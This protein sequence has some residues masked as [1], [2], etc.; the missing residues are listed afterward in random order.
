M[1]H[2]SATDL[3]GLHFAQNVAILFSESS[4][5]D[6]VRQAEESN[7]L[8]AFEDAWEHTKHWLKG[9]Y[10]YLAVNAASALLHRY[11][12]KHDIL[13]EGEGLGHGS[14]LPYQTILIP[15]AEHLLPATIEALEWWLQAPN[16][17][18][19]VT[20]KTNIPPA[21]LGIAC[22]TP[23]R[24]AGYTGWRWTPASPFSDLEMWEPFYITSYADYTAHKVQAAPGSSVLAELYEFTGDLHDGMTASKALLG[25]GIVWSGN[26]L[27]IAN[28]FLEF[29]GSVLQGHVNFEEIRNWHHPT[30][31]GDTLAYFVERILKR[32]VQPGLWQTRLR[33]FGSYE[34]V[35]SLRHDTDASDDLTMLKAEVEYLV[36]ATYNVLDHVIS[37]ESTSKEQADTWV[38]E[39]SRYDFLE[40]SLH[41]HCI[42]YEW[43]AGK[44]LMEHVVESEKRLGVTLYTLG[45]HS[46]YH[47]HPETL[48]AMDYLFETKPAMLGLCTFAYYNM[49]QYGVAIPELSKTEQTT[50]RSDGSITIAGHGF[51][52]PYHAVVTSV[53][54]HK[55]LRG[56]DLTHEYDCRYDLTEILYQGHH[57]KAP[58]RP[59]EA[60]PAPPPWESSAS[61]A[62]IPVW[63]LGDN[64]DRL[65]NGVYTIQYHPIFTKDP[66]LNN[67]RGTLP[68]LLYAI[69]LAE[70]MNFWIANKKML[71]ERMNDYQ[72][73][74]FR[75]VS[76]A[77]VD[78]YNPTRRPIQ[79][80]MIESSHPV[81]SVS[82]GT[83][84]YIHIVGKRFVT[85]P[86]M[87]PQERVTLQ[88][89]TV[90][91]NHPM[92]EQPNGKG[93]R[94]V[95][96]RYSC[97]ERKALIHLR[98]IGDQQLVV[99]NIPPNSPVQV[100]I[101]G[102]SQTK[103]LADAQGHLKLNLSATCDHFM[104][105]VVQLTLA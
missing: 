24:P 56:W 54:S 6:Y 77:Q 43:V 85:I 53:E 86:P 14:L 71:Y 67:G 13:E 72:D 80:L 101:N 50:Y 23:F 29:F 36:P 47:M 92:I 37:E 7:S 81:H 68:W 55:T 21:I 19:I 94:L 99:S 28:Q 8:Y 35:L 41:N 12:I 45:R 59:K 27:Y 22:M 1:T 17:R 40:T 20:G 25:D 33:S 15:N 4:L 63:D 9:E 31:W 46:G 103:Q 10:A 105:Q 75:V 32:L 51:W 42:G 3:K 18:L 76:D 48:D 87:A 74:K 104:D 49:L 78:I 97:S 62:G 91:G 70:R 90:D 60:T 5:M 2:E 83:W 102:T 82:D 61:S 16:T 58:R 64:F 96:A 88:I 84:E 26:T 30:H 66:L 11:N 57:S 44:K 73:I 89:N 38:R 98:L 39:T 93:L 100:S 69:H 52:W 65:E 79:E 34:G 95:D